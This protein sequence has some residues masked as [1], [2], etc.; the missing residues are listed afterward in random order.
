[1]PTHESFDLLTKPWIPCVDAQGKRV[2]FGLIRTLADAHT[3]RA[4]HDDSP[5]VTA[6]LLRLLLAVVHSALDGPVDLDDW[7]RIRTAERFPSDVERYLREWGKRF[8]LFSARWPFFQVPDLETKSLNL[9]T[10]LAHDRATGNNPVLFDHSIEERPRAMS[11]AEA[12]RQLIGNQSYALG[13]GQSTA[14]TEFGPHPYFRHAP[15]IGGVAVFLEGSTL[16]ETIA[17][18]LLAFERSRLDQPVWEQNHVAKPGPHKSQGYLE[19]LTWRSRFL[20]LV[21]AEASDLEVTSMHYVSG[22]EYDRSQLNPSFAYVSDEKRGTFPISLRD[23]RALWRDSSALFAGARAKES[24]RQP[25]VLS[26]AAELVKRKVLDPEAALQC[27]VVGLANDKAKPLFWRQERFAVPSR[28]LDD[29]MLANALTASVEYAETMGRALR[30]AVG[31]YRDRVKDAAPQLATQIDLLYW[32]TVGAKFTSLLDALG[33]DVG[34]V[35]PFQSTIENI[36]RDA[37]DRGTENV[38]RSNGR[39]FQAR[40][41]ARS[42]LSYLI[43]KNHKE[44]QNAAH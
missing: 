40:V 42:F 16:F 14:S 44:S 27:L 2:E 5:L 37:F 38:V 18:N 24:V 15:M 25:M 31:I 41:E 34:A 26:Q 17:L 23:N 11:P 22:W 33:R 4:I 43:L 3:L 12:A 35:T 8:D 1:M 29:P 28:L 36:A 10:K 21:P 20:R 39:Q 13:G 32:P 30:S 9:V 7:A 19:F 6:G